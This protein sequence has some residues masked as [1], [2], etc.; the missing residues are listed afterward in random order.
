[1]L[2]R[3]Q[4]TAYELRRRMPGNAAS[5]QR[6]QRLGV[7]A[8]EPKPPAFSVPR[9]D[10]YHGS[11]AESMQQGFDTHLWQVESGGPSWWRKQQVSGQND[12]FAGTLVIC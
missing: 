6:V 11:I 8:E 9:F 7:G 3:R 1:M 5:S 2:K 12:F 10:R 4:L